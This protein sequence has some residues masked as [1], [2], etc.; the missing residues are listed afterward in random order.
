MLYHR[1]HSWDV[2]PEQAI[3]LQGELAGR[4]KLTPWDGDPSLIAGADISF[5]LYSNIVY[6]GFVVLDFKTMEVVARSSA[7]TRVA[8]PYIPGLLSFRECPALLKAWERLE[9]DPDVVVFDGQGVAHPRRLGIAAHMGLFIERPSIGCA[10]TL[11]VGKHEELGA[12]TGAKSELVHKGEMIGYALRT[13]LKT[14]PVYVSGGHLI[15]HDNAARILLRSVR[16]YR[17]PEPTR[18]AH[19]WVNELRKGAAMAS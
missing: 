1:I 3:E 7:V 16:G 17:I 18:Q 9:V 8:M 13:K 15:D 6:A 5:E 12:L 4:V 14:N 11:L 10:K 19:L 2:T